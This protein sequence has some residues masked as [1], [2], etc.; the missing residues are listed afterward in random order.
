[1]ALHKKLPREFYF[2]IPGQPATENG[3]VYRKHRKYHIGIRKCRENLN[4]AFSASLPLKMVPYINIVSTIDIKVP[5]EFEFR[6]FGQPA[7]ENGSV[8]TL[9]PCMSYIKSVVRI[10]LTHDR[11]ACH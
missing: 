11:S 1:M 9:Y 4:F 5:R 2:C 10:G 6:I 3:P 8:C 7:T